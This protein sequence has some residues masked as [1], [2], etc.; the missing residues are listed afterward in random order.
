MSAF[1]VSFSSCAVTLHLRFRLVFVYIFEV[2]DVTPS[3]PH[4]PS[5]TGGN[6]QLPRAASFWGYQRK[7]CAHKRDIH[8]SARDLWWGGA[9]PGEERQMILSREEWRD[10]G[11]EFSALISTAPP[12]QD[13][14]ISALVDERA[15]GCFDPWA[16]PE[17]A[18]LALLNWSCSFCFSGTRL[19]G[20][21]PKTSLSL[22]W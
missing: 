7:I 6:K 5:V 21:Y 12:C 22:I 16:L 8:G 17:D 9:D 13:G 14:G 1:V 11:M 20:C 4:R 3:I 18:S 15:F 2:G 10:G 19:M